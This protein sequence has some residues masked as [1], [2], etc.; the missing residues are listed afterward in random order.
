MP[1]QWR[2]DVVWESFPFLISGIKMTVALTTVSMAIGLV[3]GLLICLARM[4]H[5]PW[6]S[7]PFKWYIDFFRGT[8]LLVQLLWAYYSLPIITG[9]RLSGYTSALVALVLNMGAFNAEVYRS[10]ITSIE[11]GQREAALALGMTWRQSMQRVILPQAVRRVIPPFGSTWVGL[12]KDTSLVSIIAVSELMYQAKVL[13]IE[14][15][16]PVEIYTVLA[17]I[18][19]VVTYP[20]ARLVDRLYDRFRVRT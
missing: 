18:Y 6:L 3:V 7:R 15:Y 10:G 9:L 14:T 12:F 4:S 1:Y 17:I 19:F 16:R 8:P 13:S 11:K 2:F 5:L 20:Q